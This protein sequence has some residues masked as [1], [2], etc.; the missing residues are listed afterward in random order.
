MVEPSRDGRADAKFV[1]T[2]LSV[3][4]EV[5][6]CVGSVRPVGHSPDWRASCDFS[7][8]V[9]LFTLKVTHLTRMDSTLVS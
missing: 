7:I 9:A 4:V 2:R 5:A 3:L 8:F 1:A 6:H